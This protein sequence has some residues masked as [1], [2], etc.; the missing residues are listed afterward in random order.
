MNLQVQKW[1]KSL[2][3]SL[4][5]GARAAGAIRKVGHLEMLQQ[6]IMGRVDSIY[7]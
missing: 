5:W 6:Q 4:L 3:V 2:E 7:F 1:K